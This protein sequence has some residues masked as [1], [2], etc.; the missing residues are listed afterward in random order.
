MRLTSPPL[1]S[2][3]ANLLIHHACLALS[4]VHNDTTNIDKTLNNSNLFTKTGTAKEIPPTA[5]PTFAEGCRDKVQAS[6]A[7]ALHL[8]G[9]S[10]IG[11][12]DGLRA[13]RGQTDREGGDVTNIIK[14]LT[15]CRGL[16]KRTVI[17]QIVYN[18]VNKPAD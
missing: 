12:H 1:E 17:G 9:V 4:R 13:G 10:C 15:S 6:A 8:E 16:P 18:V 5:Y 14:A 2:T 7:T 3:S 11:I